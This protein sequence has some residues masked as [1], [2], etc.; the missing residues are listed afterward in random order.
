[1]EVSESVLP[2]WCYYFPVFIGPAGIIPPRLIPFNATSFIIY[3]DEP[4]M[5]NGA[6]VSYSILL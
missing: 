6:I 2:Q 1:M 4:E 5:P 3:F